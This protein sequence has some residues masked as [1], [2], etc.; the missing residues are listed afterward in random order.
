MIHTLSGSMSLPFII[1]MIVFDIHRR[2]VFQIP[3]LDIV[4]APS[5][6]KT[7]PTLAWD[8]ADAKAMRTENNC[9]PTWRRT[10]QGAGPEALAGHGAITPR[11]ATGHLLRYPSRLHSLG[12]LKL[13]E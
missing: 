7:P 12:S 13:L 1:F 2:S 8:L 3:G 5:I 4:Q 10:E 9:T 11:N 6:F